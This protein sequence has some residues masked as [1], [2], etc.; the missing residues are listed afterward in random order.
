MLIMTRRVGETLIIGEDIYISIL[1]VKNK[2]VRFGINAPK[3]VKISLE[4]LLDL[5]SKKDK[6][7][8]NLTE[9]INV[10]NPNH[11]QKKD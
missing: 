6:D 9:A 1:E 3:D 11:T 10:I 8:T 5:S 7:S 2:R 4:E